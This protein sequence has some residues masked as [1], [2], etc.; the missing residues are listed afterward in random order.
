MKRAASSTPMG[1]LEEEIMAIARYRGNFPA[2]R[3]KLIMALG[4]PVM[5]RETGQLIFRNKPELWNALKQ[6]ES[7]WTDVLE[8]IGV[9]TFQALDED[10][11][12]TFGVDQ[13]ID[14][15][16]EGWYGEADTLFELA[17]MDPRTKKRTARAAFLKYMSWYDKMATPNF[18]VVYAHAT[19]ADLVSISTTLTHPV[20]EPAITPVPI[21]TALELVSVESVYIFTTLEYHT[22]TNH[23]NYFFYMRKLTAQNKTLQFTV[24]LQDIELHVPTNGVITRILKFFYQGMVIVVISGPN[25]EKLIRFTYNMKPERLIVVNEFRL[26][27]NLEWDDLVYVDETQPTHFATNIKSVAN[28]KEFFLVDLALLSVIRSPTSLFPEEKKEYAKQQQAIGMPGASSLPFKTEERDII[29]NYRRR[30]GNLKPVPAKL[31][32]I[33]V[34]TEELA[35]IRRATFPIDVQSPSEFG[36][37]AYNISALPF[38]PDFKFNQSRYII[39][40]VESLGWKVIRVPY[41]RREDRF[42]LTVLARKYLNNEGAFTVWIYIYG[43][44]K[45]TEGVY[46]PEIGKAKWIDL[47]MAGEEEKSRKP[48]VLERDTQRTKYIVKEFNIIFHNNQCYVE[49][50]QLATP[51]KQIKMMSSEIFNFSPDYTISMTTPPTYVMD[52]AFLKSMAQNHYKMYDYRHDVVTNRLFDCIFTKYDYTQR[53]IRIIVYKS[54]EDGRAPPSIADIRGTL[55]GP[56]IILLSPR[57]TTTNL[58]NILFESKPYRPFKLSLKANRHLESLPDNYDLSTSLSGMAIERPRRHA[59]C[60]FCG[61]SKARKDLESGYFYCDRVCQHLFCKTRAM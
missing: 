37:V 56:G 28:P 45:N 22:S 25:D 54:N 33:D 8:V 49:I 13:V 4:D 32:I 15:L 24:K 55:D 26:R 35:M 18:L 10:E 51:S 60:A 5:S 31:Y 42:H 14:T 12:A 9:P 23:Y 11:N 38:L 50:M 21:S 29:V 59:H 52:G 39:G 58:F 47:E 19:K 40:E 1:L 44:T 53:Q 20:A 41:E 57:H 7:F 48:L 34:S 27:A 30:T 36:N 46:V 16:G 61:T 2:R 17:K 3:M 6:D 43:Y